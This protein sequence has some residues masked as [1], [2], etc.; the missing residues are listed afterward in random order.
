MSPNIAINLVLSSLSRINMKPNKA[1][2]KSFE[3]WQLILKDGSLTVSGLRRRGKGREG[4]GRG[5][6][7]NIQEKQI[8]GDLAV[9]SDGIC[10]LPLLLIAYV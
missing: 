2:M 10:Q 1:F 7:R 4:E 6:H 3:F 5:I 8:P 9:H